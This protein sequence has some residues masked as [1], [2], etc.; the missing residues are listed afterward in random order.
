MHENPDRL[1]RVLALLANRQRREI[2]DRLVESDSEVTTVEELSRYLTRV[3][4][5]G[6]E[7]ESPSTEGARAKLHHVHLPKLEECDLVEY[8]ARS[9]KVRY[10]P[11]ERVETI[12]QFLDDL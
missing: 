10:R 2:L 7:A 6:G 11:D 3:V 9:G 8:D 4:T 5:D 12:V 1:D